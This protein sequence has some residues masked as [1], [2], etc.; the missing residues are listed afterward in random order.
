MTESQREGPKSVDELEAMLSEPDER[1]ARTLGELDGD[2]VI[3]GVGGKMGPTLARMAVRAFEE[4]GLRRRVFGVS[5]FSDESVRERLESWGVVT[6]TADLLDESV[7][8]DLPDAPLVIAMTGLKFGL[9]SD[10]PRAWAMNCYL[11]ALTCRRYARSRIAAFSSGNVYGMV[12]VNSGGSKETDSLQP[13][14]EYA[15]NVLGRERMYE[16]FCRR[17][18]IPTILLRLNYATEMRYGVLVDIGLHVWRGEP[19][20]VTMGYVNVI[21][22]RDANAMTLLALQHTAVPAAILNVA[23]PEILRVRDVA[24]AFGRIWGKPVNVVG[25]EAEDAFLNDGSQAHR[26][27]GKPSIGAETL[28]QWTAEWIAEGRELAD[29][30][31]HYENRSGSF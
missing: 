11:P 8:N 27:F 14:G 29:K 15:V 9:K 21:W 22:Q 3:L 31:T 19:L 16:F 7:W 13:Q 28:I 24:E 10:P 12:P 1:L 6:V 18:G 25:S 30:P 26:L 20:D 17:D 2:I 5:R 23:G 4:A